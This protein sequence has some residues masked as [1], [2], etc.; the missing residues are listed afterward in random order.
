MPR[1]NSS[2]YMYTRPNSVICKRQP[3]YLS[4]KDG[5]IFALLGSRRA[6]LGLHGVGVVG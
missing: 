1:P 2:S 4:D 6:R 3:C 5:L